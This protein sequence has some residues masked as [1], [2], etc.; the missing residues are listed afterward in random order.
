MRVSLTVTVDV[1]ID[2][3]LLERLTAANTVTVQPLTTSP[4]PIRRDVLAEVTLV[5][6]S[7][8]AVLTTKPLDGFT[9]DQH[10]P[11]VPN[12]TWQWSVP[13]LA[14]ASLGAGF[15]DIMKFAVPGLVEAVKQHL[16][17]LQGGA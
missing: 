8:R 4:N 11:G 5:I 1:D 3:K 17:K 13:E 9:L 16:T 7:Q 10:W 15:L 2:V 12:Y 6:P 14:Q